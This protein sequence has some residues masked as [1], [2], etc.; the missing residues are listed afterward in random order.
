MSDDQQIPHFDPSNFSTDSYVRRVD[1]PW[2]YELHFAQEDLP[3][4]SKL[5][6]INK[7]ARQ[8][9]QI[10]D[11]KQETY[12]LIKGRG[13]VLWENNKGKMIF[14]EFEQFVGYRTIIGQKHRLCSISDC[15][16]MEASTPERGTT[17]RLEDDYSRPDE[18][19][20]QRK[21]ERGE[22]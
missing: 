19:P 15:D 2:G 21:K 18:T 16:I 9:L 6:H 8:S 3:Y 13:G 11:Q 17:W 20:E 14:T 22:T 5:M 12:V 4:M 7:G 10:H 1:K